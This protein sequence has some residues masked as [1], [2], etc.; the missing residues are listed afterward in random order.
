MVR[1]QRTLRLRRE[2][3]RDLRHRLEEILDQPVVRDRENRRLG[4]LVDRDDHLAVLHAREVLDRA[5]DADR[6]VELGSYDLAG[7]PDLVFVGHEPRIDGG[8]R[9]ADRGAELIGERFEDLEVIRAA[10][11]ASAGDDDARRGELG[12][13]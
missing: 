4:V 8:A 10:H 5:R 7:L 2:L 9:G 11:A 6:Y 12:A 13:L 1:Y 3:V